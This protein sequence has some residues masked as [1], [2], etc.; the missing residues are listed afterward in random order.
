MARVWLLEEDGRTLVQGA[1]AGEPDALRS[2]QRLTVGQGLVGTLVAERVPVVTADM[3]ADPRTRHADVLRAAGLE[4][5][6][7]VPLLVGDRVLGAL[8]IAARARRLYTEEEVSLLQSLASQAAI[9]IENARLFSEERTRRAYLGA[10]LEINTKIGALA[11][12]E[13]LLGTI[14]EEAARLLDVDNAGFRL[15]E[16]DSLVVAGLAGLAAETMLRPRLKV[17]ESISGRV[18]AAG[19]T[20][21]LDLDAVEDVVP[22][23]LAADQ[24]LGYTTFLGVPLKVGTRTIGVLGFRARRPFTARDQELAEAFAGQAAVAIEH[25]RL[26]REAA[27]QAEQMA[28]LADVGRLVSG[29]LDPDLAAQRIADSVR[30][31]FSALSST[32]FRLERATGDLVMLAASGDA[33]F[34]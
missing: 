26:Y 14:A 23:H 2:L 19:R 20:L 25:S 32:L 21:V 5:F 4:S 22:E 12:R 15:L 11:P 3:P 28:A 1:A 13:A 24:R 29:T 18:V 16:G 34:T 33:D 17:G 27:G 30:R 9:A 7:G 6:A 10:L 31:L 8:A